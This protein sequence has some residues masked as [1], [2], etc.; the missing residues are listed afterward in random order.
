MFKLI[1]I[2]C[3][4]LLSGCQLSKSVLIKDPNE[5]KYGQISQMKTTA[6]QDEDG[7]VHIVHAK[8]GKATCKFNKDGSTELTTDNQSDTLIE[9]IKQIMML[10][11]VDEE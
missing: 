1:P 11:Y 3:M 10:K 2:V 8:N 6:W 4:V 7:K 5:I 9:Q